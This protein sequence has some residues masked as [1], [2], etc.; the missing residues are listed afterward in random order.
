MVFTATLF[1]NWSPQEFFFPPP[2][3]PPV[4][5]PP[6]PPPLRPL[7]PPRPPL[8]KTLNYVWRRDSVAWK[9]RWWSRATTGTYKFFLLLL[10][11]AFM[12]GF[13]VLFWFVLFFLL[14][15]QFLS[16]L[17]SVGF[18]C[19]SC[20]RWVFVV[21]IALN[22]VMVAMGRVLWHGCNGWGFLLW[23]GEL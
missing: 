23:W 20:N 22:G 19:H 15:F 10:N 5:P 4:P 2:S 8:P 18:F 1:G 13:F 3:S 9:C 12:F 17:Q 21:M 11:L 16:W 7:L 6:P 14:G